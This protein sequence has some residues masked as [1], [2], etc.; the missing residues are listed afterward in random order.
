MAIK[1]VLVVG[2]AGYIGSHMTQMLFDKGYSVDVFDNS[3]AKHKGLLP[4]V[5]KIKGDLRNYNDI[6]GAL[7]KKKYDLVM[8]FAGLIIAP[9]S[10]VLPVKYYESNVIGAIN[11]I[12]AIDQTGVTKLIFSSTAAVYG[13]PK[14]IP[15]SED[16]ELKPVNPYGHTKLMFEQVLNDY[17]ASNNK[18]AFIALRYFNAA[19]AHELGHIGECHQPET[20]LIPNILK[21]IKGELKEFTLFGT[22]YPTKDGT[23]IRDYIH[24]QDL[25]EGH[26][27]AIKALDKG[28]KNEKFNLGSGS[29]YSVKE[30]INVV[31][32]VTGKKVKVKIAP[33]RPGDPAKLVAS[34]AKAKKV[35]GWV[36]QRSLETIIQSA[37]AWE[38]KV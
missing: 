34:H 35:L 12:K 15:I 18:F 29:G 31:E 2:G 21:N 13:N 5:T 14:R 10:A 22:D 23:C 25:C 26:F 19:G 37:W 11:L 4:K 33:R 27:L 6:Y 32:Q 30:I 36:P 24:V 38:R 20:H 7:K 1:K 8:F 3:Y 9:E 17:S 16:S 28:I